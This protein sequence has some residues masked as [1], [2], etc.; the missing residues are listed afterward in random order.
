MNIWNDSRNRSVASIWFLFSDRILTPLQKDAWA[1]TIGILQSSAEA[2]AKLF[3]ALTLRGKVGCPL[4]TT[5]S[6]Y[7]RQK[8]LDY[9]RFGDPGARKRTTCSE[10]PAPSSAETICARSK[11]DPSPAVRVFGDIGYTDE[12]VEGCSCYGGLIPQRRRRKP[13]L[14]PGFPPG[15]AGRSDRGPQNHLD[16]TWS[17][18]ESTRSVSYPS[19]LFSSV[20]VNSDQS[21]I[22]NDRKK[23]LHNELRSCSPTMWTRWY[24][25]SSATRSHLVSPMLHTLGPWLISSQQLPPLKIRS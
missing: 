3:A 6:D 2:E 14:H 10:E 24:S 1:T 22:G 19:A 11:A 20:D 12:G 16:C 17:A 8:I 21:L 7:S 15:S 23:S 13:R 18:K 25:C 9:L 4:D 5:C